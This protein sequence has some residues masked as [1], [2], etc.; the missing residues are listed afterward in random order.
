M[1]SSLGF[2]QSFLLE[3]QSTFAVN[4]LNILGR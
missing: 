1:Q 4:D 3:A 2:I